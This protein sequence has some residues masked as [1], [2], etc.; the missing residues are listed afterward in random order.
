MK[1]SLMYL[2]VAALLSGAIGCSFAARNPESYR[3]DTQALLETKRAEIEQC[4]DRE[5][6]TDSTASGTVVV[7]FTVQSETGKIIDAAIDRQRTSAPDT[8]GACVTQTIA[9]LRLAPPDQSDGN[10]T[11]VY[12]FTVGPSPAAQPAPNTTSPSTEASP[13]G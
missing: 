4:Y 3:D 1:Q 9:T 8:L 7:T 2:T 6:E 13:A 5:L 10:A 11:F 12:E